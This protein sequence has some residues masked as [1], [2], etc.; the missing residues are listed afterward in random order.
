MRIVNLK[1]FLRSIIIILLVIFALSLV[2][3]KASLSHREIEY[4]TLYVTSGDTLWNI[5]KDLQ[6]NNSYYKGR[7]IREIISNIKDINNLES[8]NLYVNQEL[9]IPIV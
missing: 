1:K 5:A 9:M 8:S 2:C 4:T 6:S 7:D 3:A